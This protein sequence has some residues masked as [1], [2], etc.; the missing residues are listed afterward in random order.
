MNGLLA[1]CGRP[2]FYPSI[3]TMRQMEHRVG[4]L[5]LV[6]QV[7]EQIGREEEPKTGF[8]E[9]AEGGGMGVQE[10]G[11]Q[12]LPV[13]LTPKRTHFVIRLRAFETALEEAFA[14]KLQCLKGR[15]NLF[16]HLVFVAHLILSST[17]R[18]TLDVTG[19]RQG[20]P[21]GG[22]VGGRVR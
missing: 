3:K 22:P 16:H 21:V 14:W 11:F 13:R 10:G 17:H 18:S 4:C 12:G 20:Q 19:R 5:E 2:N 8:G 1:F 9:E 6:I 15:V 7:R